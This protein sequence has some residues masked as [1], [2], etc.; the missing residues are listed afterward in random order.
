[1]ITKTFD[2]RQNQSCC[3]WKNNQIYVKI[4]LALTFVNV[5]F[6]PLSSSKVL[7]V[8]QICSVNLTNCIIWEQKQNGA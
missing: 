4:I 7:T 5:F 6:Y 8:I 1:M 2:Y 3:I